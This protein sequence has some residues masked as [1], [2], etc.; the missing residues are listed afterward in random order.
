MKIRSKLKKQSTIKSN[1]AKITINFFREIN[2]YLHK[3]CEVVELFAIGDDCF[4]EHFVLVLDAYFPKKNLKKVCN[5]VG[6]V[7]LIPSNFFRLTAVWLVSSQC[8]NEL[9]VL[10]RDGSDWLTNEAPAFWRRS[11]VAEVEVL[12]PPNVP[13]TELELEGKRKILI[14]YSILDY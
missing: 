8:W 12:G 5:K 2:A 13:P 14:M 1:L 10:G 3:F 4:E 11:I 6:M 9:D 7:R